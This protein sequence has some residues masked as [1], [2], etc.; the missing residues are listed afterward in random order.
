M[1][2]PLDSIVAKK[3]FLALVEFL[4]TLGVEMQD[5]LGQRQWLSDTKTD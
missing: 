4:G 2:K 1:S 3:D 5:S